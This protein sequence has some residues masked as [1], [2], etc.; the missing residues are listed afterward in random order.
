MVNAIGL[1]KFQFLYGTIQTDLLNRMYVNTFEFQFLYGT[2]QTYMQTI[3]SMHPH[4]R[5]NSYTVQFKP[6]LCCIFRVMLLPGFNS[7]TVQFKPIHDVADTGRWLQFQFLYGTI[8]TTDK[9]IVSM[10][11]YTFQFLYGTIQTKVLQ[12]GQRICGEVSIPIRYNSNLIM[13]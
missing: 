13:F 1:K 7:Y 11:D 12:E 10:Y 3:A 6:Y 2:I 8:Q 5:F 4:S 9:L